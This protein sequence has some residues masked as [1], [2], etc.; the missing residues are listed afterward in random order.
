M[1]AMPARS[2]ELNAA[3]VQRVDAVQNNHEDPVLARLEQSAETILNITTK[4]EV[5]GQLNGSAT[6]SSG[7]TTDG[8]FRYDYKANLLLVAKTL[9]LYSDAQAVRLNS[10]T[11]VG[12][13]PQQTHDAFRRPEPSDERY[14]S[15]PLATSVWP[16]LTLSDQS[17][18]PLIADARVYSSRHNLTL[19]GAR[20]SRTRLQVSAEQGKDALTRQT[21]EEATGRDVEYLLLTHQQRNI[22]GSRL[23]L[24]LEHTHAAPSGKT[25]W[26]LVGNGGLLDTRSSSSLQLI[27][28]TQRD[29]FYQQNQAHDLPIHLGAR[30]NQSLG[31]GTAAQLYLLH[32]RGTLDDVSTVDVD[33]A[34]IDFANLNF[35]Q[36][37]AT[38]HQQRLLDYLR[39]RGG[40]RLFFRS[41]LGVGQVFCSNRIPPHTNS[42][43]IAALN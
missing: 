35:T 14:V 39:W 36:P 41:T 3:I 11:A 18:L 23:L 9:G 19:Q 34:E 1:K 8:N 29:S 37:T 25:S 26:R 24:D 17:P 42:T 38:L 7:A 40:T 6:A 13:L 4:D 28:A 31:T 5:K 27:D 10:T 32:D 30:L 22:A 15:A 20:G 21:T 43:I 16:G 2:Q 12:R 33:S